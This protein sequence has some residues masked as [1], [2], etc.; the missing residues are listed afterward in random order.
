MVGACPVHDS[1]SSS[2]DEEWSSPVPAELFEELSSP[3]TAG[4]SS[5]IE[6]LDDFAPAA[7]RDEMAAAAVCMR[8]AKAGVYLSV[9]LVSRP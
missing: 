3:A 7:D 9:S 2:S 6:M 5:F 8:E 1:S 4:L